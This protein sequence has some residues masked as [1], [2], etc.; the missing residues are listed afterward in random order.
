MPT[1]TLDPPRFAQPQETA[2]DAFVLELRNYL[3]RSQSVG[4]LA[5][6]PTL[7]KYAVGYESGTDPYETTV[8]ILQEFPDVLE[9]LPHVSV[10]AGNARNKRLSIG[11][12]VLGV[13]QLAP[14]VDTVSTEPFALAA[15]EVLRYRTMPDGVNWTASS[16]TFAADRFPTAAPVTAALAADVARVIN[17]QSLYAYATALPSG[18]VRIATGGVYGQGRPNAIEVLATTD[19]NVLSEFGLAGGEADDTENTARPPMLRYHQATELSV[20]I[21]VICAD[22][23]TRRELSDLLYSWSTFWLERQHFELYGRGVFDPEAYPDEHYQISMHQ[24]ITLGAETAVPR[25]GDQK[26]KVHTQRVTVPCTL[27]HY[28]DRSVT[29]VGGP[30]DGDNWTLDSADISIA[31]DEDL[32]TPN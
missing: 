22:S 7:Q 31:T 25:P 18:A 15:G 13:V 21:D 6:M 16:V 2:C 19:A 5:E 28:I 9:N 1:D 8:Q 30:S 29:V 3:N 14:R 27:I 11:R 20:N 17:E 23:N 24:E 12:P 10:T 32:P 26:D 4:R